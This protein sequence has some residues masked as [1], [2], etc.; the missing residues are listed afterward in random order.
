MRSPSARPYFVDG[1]APLTGSRG[2]GPS[3]SIR[4]EWRDKR[5]E[6]A[7]GANGAGGRGGGGGPSAGL[8]RGRAGKRLWQ[9][10]LPSKPAF[11]SNV[12][13]RLAWRAAPRLISIS[14]S[15][16]CWAPQSDWGN[17][18]PEGPSRKT[19]ETPLN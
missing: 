3:A 9:R 10:A 1:L 19:N 4:F 5:P 16:L 13:R 18:S 6:S 17:R 2:T 15:Y 12:F 8:A 11:G 7:V 14:I